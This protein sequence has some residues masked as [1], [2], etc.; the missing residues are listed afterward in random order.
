MERITANN[1]LHGTLLFAAVLLGSG[2]GREDN[3]DGLIERH[4]VERVSLRDVISQ[5]G[6]VRPVVKIDLQSEASGK[7]EKVHV[8]EGQRVDQGDTILVIDPSRLLYKKKGIDLALRRAKLELE[9]ARRDLRDAERLTTTGTI[10]QRKL[11]D[12]GQAVERTE[13]E[14]Q[15]QKLELDDIVDQL[16]KTVVT[17]PMGGVI[18]EFNVEEGEIA[19]SATSGFQ[20]GTKLATIAD[21]GRLEVVTQIGEVDYVH[22]Q[23]GQKVAI[24]P[25]AIRD[26]ETFG[27]IDFIALAAKKSGNEGLGTFEVRVSIDSLV[28]GIAPGVNV[29]VDFVILEKENVPGIPNHF[30]RGKE[31]HH[32]V[33][34]ETAEGTKR[35][36]VQIGETDYRHYEILSGLSEGDVVVF[37]ESPEQGSQ[38]APGGRGRKR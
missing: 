37:T 28:T 27:T 29:A 38:K 5:T 33:M 9:T 13:I 12:L 17:S 3:A 4:T 23:H 18:T 8:R 25:E 6:E 35:T 16:G 7:I 34:V 11:F 32:F 20:A 30:V 26:S 21:I 1:L 22:L 15:R 10:A 31:G 36:P 19:V 24:H 14:Y 2:C